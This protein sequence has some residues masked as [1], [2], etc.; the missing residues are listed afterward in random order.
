MNMIAL[1]QLQKELERINYLVTKDY[2]GEELTDEERTELDE[3]DRRQKAALDDIITQ[4]R[5]TSTGRF[6]ASESQLANP[7][8]EG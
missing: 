3:I 8:R 6:S 1:E 4:Y 7:P 5:G 2:N